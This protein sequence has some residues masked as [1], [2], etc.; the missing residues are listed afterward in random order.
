MRRVRH[1][2]RKEFLELRQDPRL[3][4]IVIMAPLVQLTM[5]GY[6]ATTDVRNVPIVVV[7]EDRSAPS[8]DLIA[9]FDAS[10]NFVIVDV[11]ASLDEIDGYLD[12]GR[13][14]MALAIPAAY[15]ERVRTGQPVSVQVVADGTDANSTNV[16]LGYAGAL[17]VSYARELAAATGRSATPLVGADVRVWFNPTLESRHFMIPGILALL[18]LVVCATLSSMAIVREKELGTLEQLNVT[19]LSRWELIVGK[20]VPYAMIGMF[21]V[22][23]VVAVAVGW[24]EVPLRGSF[25][26]LLLMCLVYLLTALGLGLFVSTISRTQQQAMM[27]TSFFFLLPMIFLSGFIFPIENMPDVIQRV[28]YLIPLR[29]FL[30]ILRGIFLKGV[31]LEVFWPDALALLG[32][33][34]AILTLATL[35]STKRLA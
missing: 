3:F 26:L 27:T 25:G 35:R 8:R 4:G 29:Y 14:W 31:G 2:M 6:A 1:L 19:P 5:L 17:V 22:L 9:R 10:A 18:L 11:L 13:A 30:V 24:F 20:L 12:G 16:A 28:T 15:G 23:L 34:V 32:W 21:D 33:G 7:D